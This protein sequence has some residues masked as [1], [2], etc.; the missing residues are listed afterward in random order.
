M[1]VCVCVCVCVRVVSVRYFRKISLYFYSLLYLTNY[2]I[3]H[4]IPPPFPLFSSSPAVMNKCLTILLNILVWDKHAEPGGIVC[5][6]ICIGGGMIYKQA[7]M[8]GSA[9]ALAKLSSV[10]SDD[11]DSAFKDDID[12]SAVE[13][14]NSNKTN[15]GSGS[16][17]NSASNETADLLEKQTAANK[18]RG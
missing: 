11:D 10:N 16:A 2:F 18:R 9:A 12:L 15:G 17:P 14:N 4:T 7:P 13:M 8:R 6:F 3:A 5:L 1:R